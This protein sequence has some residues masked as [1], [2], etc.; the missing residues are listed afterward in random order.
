MLFKFASYLLGTNNDT[1][2]TKPEQQQLTIE[3]NENTHDTQPS[4]DENSTL[5]EDNQIDEHLSDEK[6]KN[7]SCDKQP[8]LIEE[9]DYMY[10]EQLINCSK[11]KNSN[12]NLDLSKDDHLCDQLD[13]DCEDDQWIYITPI[14]RKNEEEEKEISDEFASEPDEESLDGGEDDKA[15][16][17]ENV[18]NTQSDELDDAQ[19]AVEQE[20]FNFYDY[21]NNKTGLD[22]LSEEQCSP[23]KSSKYSPAAAVNGKKLV[24]HKLNRMEESWAIYP[25]ACFTLDNTFTIEEHPMENLYIENPALS[26]IASCKSIDKEN[27]GTSSL[28]NSLLPL[29]NKTTST[30]RVLV[31]RNLNGQPK[32]AVTGKSMRK[33]A[34]STRKT[35]KK[36]NNKKSKNPQQAKKT[37]QQA[38]VKQPDTTA[39]AVQTTVESVVAQSPTAGEQKQVLRERHEKQL[40]AHYLTMNPGQLAATATPAGNTIATSSNSSTHQ[41]THHSHNHNHTHHHYISNNCVAP[42]NAT[43]TNAGVEHKKGSKSL[44]R[45]NKVALKRDNL[46]NKPF[47]LHRKLC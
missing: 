39:T 8:D 27:N 2:D 18:P 31:D 29:S 23:A 40:L 26:V 38:V 20:K 37:E 24:N 32:A 41:S 3:S 43:S 16:S 14:K 47:T 15:T 17:N 11:L 10:A 6:V 46:S 19:D 22:T 35:N 33:R 42:L 12:C 13:D 1:D 45:N 5:S 34:N 9:D 36:Q 25:P 44:R 21:F 7:L 30:N 28:T 4:L